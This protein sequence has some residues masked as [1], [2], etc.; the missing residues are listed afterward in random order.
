MTESQTF[1][2]PTECRVEQCCRLFM[3]LFPRLTVTYTVC[4]RMVVPRRMSQAHGS[5]YA[6]GIHLDAPAVP[7]NCNLVGT[8]WGDLFSEP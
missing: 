5:S 1:F 8:S 2:L 6:G 3:G 7:F 4:Y